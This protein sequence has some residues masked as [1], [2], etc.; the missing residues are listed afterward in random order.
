M[1]RIIFLAGLLIAAFAVCA[2]ADVQLYSG[3]GSI[4][5]VPSIEEAAR[6][7]VPV[8]DVGQIFG[9][10]ARRNGEELLLAKGNTQIRFMLN[11]GAAWRGM[12]IVPL[13]SAPFERGGKFWIDSQSAASLFQNYAGRGQN[14]RLRFVKGAP[15]QAQTPRVVTASS[16]RPATQQ[17]STSSV[18][19]ATETQPQQIIT[20]PSVRQETQAQQLITTSS[21][22]PQPQ[23]VITA[24][25]VRPAAQPEQ[26]IT[27]SNIRQETQQISASNVRQETQQATTRPQPQ[28]VITAANVRPAQP[29]AD[30]VPARRVTVLNAAP[31]QPQTV[32]SPAPTQPVTPST[33]AVAPQPAPIV[34]TDTT[35]QEEPEEIDI[36]EIDSRLRE[37]DEALQ[38][39]AVT[40]KDTP[41]VEVVS[42]DKPEAPQLKLSTTQ[43]TASIED[44]D[45]RLKEL[46][47][48]P[49]AKAKPAKSEKPKAPKAPAK[50]QPRLETFKPD[51]KPEKPQQYSGTIQGIRWTSS[52]N[53]AKAVVE[54]DEAAEPQVF[55]AD[56]SIHALFAECSD[57]AEGLS[58][59]YPNITLT[60]NRSDDGVELVFTPAGFT[61]AEK[62]VLNNPRRIAFDF[63]FPEDAEI[64][65]DSQPQPDLAKTETPSR[66]KPEIPEAPAITTPRTRSPAVTTPPSSITIPATPAANGRKTVVID[67]GH[68]GKDPGAS[69]NGVI[70]KNINLAVGLEL[71]KILN[72]RG[73]RVVMT[74]QTD[75]YLTL[76]ERTDIANAQNAD[77]F[78]SVHVN[79][80]PSRKSMTGFEIYIMALPTDKDAME[81]AKVE[82]REYVEGKGMDVANVDRR[83]EML[84]KILGDMQQNNKISESTDFAAVLYNAGAVNGLPMRRIAQAPFF[85]LRGAGMPAVLLEIGFLT[86]ATEAQMLVNPVYQQKM[87][88]AMAAGIVNYLK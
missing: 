88:N 76:Q 1:R 63:S 56:G 20:A 75:V 65:D 80:L 71:A 19:L 6:L 54:T 3:T 5:V 30:S 72:A 10:A 51:D 59:P 86:N 52:T 13:Y 14:N 44:I 48:N 87:A 37:L 53:K 82:N 4:G 25:N 70:E 21:A 8:E 47:E 67:P 29:Q 23:P 83:T 7:F 61:K 11:A 31:S 40:H 84:L 38:L 64:A 69:G 50:P 33:P 39:D 81:L 35:T 60:L 74:R 24:P 16:V 73:F 34:D 57:N 9:F 78:V 28:S 12:S 77:L 32:A 36:S 17:L 66:P 27:A 68:G 55:F 18:R 58:S 45:A 41:V 62:L 22:R 46:D 15:V 85:V 49:K 26:I 42:P 79:A 2:W 43:E